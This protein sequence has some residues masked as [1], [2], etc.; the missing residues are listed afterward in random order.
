MISMRISG[1]TLPPPETDMPAAYD[2]APDIHAAD[3]PPAADDP[4]RHAEEDL[5]ESNRRL[6]Q[7]EARYRALFE[8]ADDGFGIIERID[9]APGEPI[10]FRCVAANR[11]FSRQSGFEDVTG[12][13]MRDVLPG[14][15]EEWFEIYDT[16]LRTGEPVRFERDLETIGQTLEIHAFPVQEPAARHV[17]TIFRNVTLRKRSQQALQASE[18]RQAFLL[19]LSDALRPLADPGEIQ[20]TASRLLGEHLG[21]DRVFYA[22]VVADGGIDYFRIERTYHTAGTPNITGRYPVASFGRAVGD[23]YRAGRR[24]AIADVETDDALDSADRAA[25]AAVGVRAFI[26]VPLIKDGRFVAA[27]GVNQREARPWQPADESL[28]EA[29]AERTWAAVEQA[30]AEAALRES[31][32]RL[33]KAMSADT[34]GVLFFDLRGHIT[35]ANEAFESMSGYTREELR[36]VVHWSELTP[37]EFRSLTEQMAKELGRYGKAAPYEKQMV[38]KDGSRWWGL[39]APTRLAGTGP[40]TQ[41]VEFIVDITARKEA[42]TAL[43]ESEERYRTLFESIDQG[44]CT[45]EVLSDED[46]QPNDYVFLEVNSAFA[47]NTGL[48]DAVGKR[49]RDLRPDHEQFW[50]D[51]YGRVARTGGTERFE[52]EARALGRWYSVYAY[53]VG[54]PERRR[55]A[56]LFE[57]ITARRQAEEATRESRAELERQAQ[58]LDATLSNVGDFISIWDRQARFVYAN[59]ALESLWGRRRKAYAGKTAT[60]LGYPPDQVAFFEEAIARVFRTKRVVT[61]ELPYT[62]PA[63]TAGYYEIVFSPV[64]GLGPRPEFV[65]GVSRDITGRKRREA[66]AAFLTE[67]SDDFARLTSPDDIMRVVGEKMYRHFDLTR[68]AF[69]RVDETADTVTSVHDQHA[70]G[71][72]PAQRVI[73]LSDFVSDAYLRRLR[74][75]QVYALHDVDTDPY[76]AG[77]AGAFK[78]LGVG[79]LLIAPFVSEGRW[80]FTITLQ[81]ATPYRWQQAEIAL[82]QDLAPRLYLALERARAGAAIRESEDRF[83]TVANLVPDLL[84]STDPDGQASWYSQRLL[85]YTGQARDD[86]FDL[87]WRHVIHPDDF[88]QSDRDFSDALATGRSFH[89]EHRLRRHDGEYRWFLARA[90]PIH[91][92]TGRIVQWFGAATDIHDARLV[93]DELAGQVALATAELRSLS[94]QLLTVQEEERRHLARELHDEIGQALTALQLQLAAARRTPAASLS[95]AEAIVHELT[96]RVSELSMDLRPAALDTLGL[97]PALLWHSQ[98]YEARTGVHVDL[99]H[100]GLDRRLPPKIEIA[101]YR[102]VQEALT[103]VARHAGID[104]VSVQLLADDRLTIVIRDRGNGFDAAAISAAGGL[105]GMRERVELLG[106]SLGIEAA[107]GAGV[108]ITAEIPLDR[109]DV[110]EMDRAS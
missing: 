66:Q 68:I 71:L 21:V 33:Q 28:V 99:R 8:A 98:R 37:S 88:E 19:R 58:F 13:T 48:V 55:V 46:G 90:E 92:E 101:A 49:M 54:E 72:A 36:D 105:G 87:G 11:V 89:R 104:V 17:G 82:L 85:D 76:A 5:V 14:E 107:D 83:R 62:S 4:E 93:R 100:H 7:S 43:G 61:G 81:K 73:R 77:R 18:A 27:F 24:M 96:G 108:V 69:A 53:R 16:V 78:A 79:A 38:R 91:D 70:A 3:G 60:E 12:M 51:T 26:G 103:N 52:H 10:N 97:V 106:G 56:V 47:R 6:R 25:F 64:T 86:L 110:P 9:T 32:A 57:D 67:V 41:C 40:D 34:V 42:E 50:F 75:G 22:E 102:V 84:W 2:P 65:V 95:D 44:F 15:F 31:E 94:R 63:G 74:T 109:D 29:V 39:F 59:R 45:I 35:D 23:T 30:R 1:S 20:A 80:R